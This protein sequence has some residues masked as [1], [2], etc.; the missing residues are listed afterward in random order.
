MKPDAGGPAGRIPPWLPFLVL[1][2]GLAAISFGAILVRLAQGGGVA[3]L[4]IA[5]WRLGL[6]ALLVTPWVLARHYSQLAALNRRQLVL[7][8][9]AGAALALHFATW[10]SSLE[11]TS[12]ASSTAL[13]TTNPLWIGIA[14][15]VLFGERPKGA[16]LLA[17]ALSLAGSLLI[18][19][20]DARHAAHG[21]AP[22]LGNALALGGSWCFAAYLMIGR[23]LRVGL[24]LAVYVWLA[25]GVAGLFLFA[26][27]GA[28]GAALVG[29]DLPSWLALVGLAVVPQMIGHTSYN[30]SLKH[31]SATFV[32]VVTLG[33]PIGSALLA[34]VF[35]G[36]SL[37]R[38]QAI[39][40]CLL[41]TGIYL[42]ARSS[43]L[44]RAVPAPM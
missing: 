16:M 10:I 1:G 2:I 38:W 29:F 42:A 23:R 33:E 30:W 43:R 15:F 37:A 40:F 32:A 13:V 3:S 44:E 25:Y 14:S 24:T 12:V 39:G 26:A 4:A 19:L 5:A 21:A 27:A 7:A 35:F 36:E 22:L 17:I 18:F 8:L 9:A 11:Y 28:S 31:V 20:S 6:A 34:F 41:L